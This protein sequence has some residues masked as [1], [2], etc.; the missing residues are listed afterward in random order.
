MADPGVGGLAIAV[1]EGLDGDLR[2]RRSIEAAQID[3]VAVGV[4]ARYVEGFHSAAAAEQV[5][6]DAG[7]EPVLSERLLSAQQAKAGA[8]Y[9]QVEVPAHAADR[10]VA[11]AHR[12]PGRRLHL[13]GDGAA[14][15]AAAVGD[16]CVRH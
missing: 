11:L 16:E 3:A 2:E 5:P 1:V 6:R 15:T 12:D 10:A 8:R 7:V 14:M 4:G 9:D 13:E